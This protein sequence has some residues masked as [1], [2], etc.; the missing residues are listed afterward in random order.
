MRSDVAFAGYWNAPDKDRETIRDGWIY[1]GDMASLD[2]DGY[3]YLA[4]ARSSGIKTGGYNVFPT[5]VE[6]VL[7]EH[8]AVNEVAVVGLPDPRWGERIH[9]CRQHPCRS[10]GHRGR[11]ARL[12]SRQDRC[13]KIPKSIEI[14]QELPKGPTGKIQKR[15]I[16]DHYAAS[17][18]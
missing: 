4:T 2:D 10:G 12:L 14:W 1:T 11:T 13:F 3:V 16:I 18:S 17:P 9:A 7:A 8:P 15:S 5:E 6:N